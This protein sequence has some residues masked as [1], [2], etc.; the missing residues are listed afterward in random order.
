MVTQIERFVF[1]SFDAESE[2]VMAPIRVADLALRVATPSVELPHIPV[3]PT[4]SLEELEQQKKEAY[5]AGFKDAT[6]EAEQ[7]AKNEALQTEKALQATLADLSKQLTVLVGE[8]A[9]LLESKQKELADLVLS[10]ARK[11]AGSA[12]KQDPFAPVSDLLQGCLDALTEDQKVTIFVHPTLC[13]ALSKKLPSITSGTGF[14][15]E[16][17]VAADPNITRESCR[18]EWP[19]GHAEYDPAVIWQTLESLIKTANLAAASQASEPTDDAGNTVYLA[20]R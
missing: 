11:V 1:Q 6:K 17:T 10:I 14:T 7:R 20:N 9:K 15:A 8:R 19:N 13:T 12:L 18:I 4:F 2:S 5:A 16:I 3:E